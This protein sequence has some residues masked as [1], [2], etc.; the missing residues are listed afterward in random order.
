M[1]VAEAV[2]LN[3]YDQEKYIA[4][5]RYS[6]YEEQD[7]ILQNTPEMGSFLDIGAWHPLVFSNTRAL[8]ERGWNGALI[9]PAPG[10]FLNLL[11]ACSK[12]GRVFKEFY[13]ERKPHPCIVCGGELRYGDDPRLKLVLAAVHGLDRTVTSFHATDDAL[14]T[15]EDAHYEKWRGEGGFYGRFYIPTITWED[16]FNRFGC[17]HFIN[18]DIEGASAHLFFN[19]M[20]DTQARPQCICLEHDGQLIEIQSRAAEEKYKVVYT[21][22]T[23]L[24]LA[25]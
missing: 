6:Q 8:F 12:C 5:G 3:E 15:S 25:R 16:I 1:S 23:N 18:I 7:Y 4:A 22:G 20:N 2:N 9:E 17:F 21:N 14:T 24:V 10:P 11:R 19:L 13:G